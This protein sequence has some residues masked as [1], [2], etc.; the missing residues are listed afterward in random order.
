MKKVRYEVPEVEVLDVVVEAGFADSDGD[1]NNPNN[2]SGGGEEIGGGV[3]GD[4][5]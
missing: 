1:E 5:W 2:G 4:D 3:V